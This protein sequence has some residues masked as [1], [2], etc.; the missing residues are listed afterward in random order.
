MVFIS[1]AYFTLY[2]GHTLSHT[3]EFITANR[4]YCKLNNRTNSCTFIIHM[5]IM[6]KTTAA[7]VFILL[8]LCHTAGLLIIYFQ[9]YFM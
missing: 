9:V 6:T 3:F 8:S 7:S 5:E 4:V 1:L 2:N